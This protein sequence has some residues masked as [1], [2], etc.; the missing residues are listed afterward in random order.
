[1]NLRSDKFL[2]KLK[3]GDEER[4]QIQRED[5]LNPERAPDALMMH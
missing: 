2:Q 4:C 1:L 5:I 3:N